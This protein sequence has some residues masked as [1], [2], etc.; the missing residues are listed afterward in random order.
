MKDRAHSAKKRGGKR[1]WP[2]FAASIALGAALG[3]LGARWVDAL[4]LGFGGLIGLIA[5]LAAGWVLSIPIHEAGHWAA[6][7]LGGYRLVS[8]AVGPLVFTGSEGRVRLHVQPLGRG[9][10]GLCMMLPPVDAS[11]GQRMLY[12]AGGI[13]ANLLAGALALAAAGAGGLAAPFFAAAGV[14]NLLMAAMN[15]TPLRLSGAS[16]DGRLLWGLW[17]GAPHVRRQIALEQAGARL[18]AGEPFADVARSLPPDDGSEAGYTFQRTFYGYFAALEA[19]DDAG[20]RALLEEMLALEGQVLPIAMVPAYYEG[21]YQALLTG[22][23]PAAEHWHG[24]AAQVLAKDG[25]ANG[26]RVRAT[27]AL[28]HD[29]DAGQAR[30]LAARG[31]AAVAHYPLKAQA[32]LEKRLLE[33]LLERAEAGGACPPEDSPAPG[34]EECGDASQ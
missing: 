26:L 5:G 1:R 7:A 12:Y 33:Q 13:L 27:W 31:L 8:W 14:V 30:A 32:A 25:D 29:G 21:C 11:R 20:A 3:F 10:G 2:I 15:F 4:D 24:R 23:G 18:A 9:V 19:G 34:E 22:D 16:S 17:T 6:G 28:Y